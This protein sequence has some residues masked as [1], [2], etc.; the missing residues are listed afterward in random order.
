MEGCSS[1]TKDNRQN[2]QIQFQNAV[3]GHFFIKL[4]DNHN[5]L[6]YTNLINENSER[7]VKMENKIKALL[8]PVSN[9]I[10]QKLRVHG[11]MTAN[12]L[13]DSGI[14]VSRATL[15]RKLDKMLSLGIIDVKKT[16]V[17]RGQVEKYYSVKEI[18][19]TDQTDNEER[20][21]T[22]TLGLMNI[23]CQYEGYFKDEN[24]DVDRDKLFMMNYHIALTD[25][26]FGSM[27]QEML[28]VVDR[29]QSRV[30]E[31]AKLRNL[32]LMSA[33]PEEIRS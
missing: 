28:A 8:D 21:K 33:P 30:G 26:D 19:I 20:L 14:E 18:Y 3:Y 23:A 10:I 24:A 16:Q 4:L 32:Y 9:Q 22:V 6:N 5:M 15:Y 13:L 17:I 2:A 31:G 27:L 11:S 1:I 12:N 7:R 29:Y 25:E